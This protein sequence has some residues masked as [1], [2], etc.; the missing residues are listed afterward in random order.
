MDKLQGFAG[1]LFDPP[2][3]VT[4]T[5]IINHSPPCKELTHLFTNLAKLAAKPF[6]KVLVHMLFTFGLGLRLLLVLG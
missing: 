1:N 5:C 4:V 2:T 6:S 3:S